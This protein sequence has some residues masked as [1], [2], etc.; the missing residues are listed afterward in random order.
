MEKDNADADLGGDVFKVR[1]ARSNEGKSG[2]YRVIVF[3]R[4]GEKTFFQYLFAKS[5]RDNISIKEL[6]KFKDNAKD[7]MSMTDYEIKKELEA[8]FLYEI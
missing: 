8:G 2:G 4:K 3:F 5:E 6:K 7:F 1:M